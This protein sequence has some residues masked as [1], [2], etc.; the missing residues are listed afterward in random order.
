MRFC[1]IIIVAD[2][3]HFSESEEIKMYE[4]GQ[5]VVYKIAGVCKIV[6]YEQKT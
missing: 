1:D 4:V 6:G 3:R 5:C 2:N